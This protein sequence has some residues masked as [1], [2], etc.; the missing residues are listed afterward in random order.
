MKLRNPWLIRLA[1]FL[2]AGVVRLWMNTVRYRY[3]L[4]G[5]HVHPNDPELD[6]RYVYAFWHEAML[7]PGGQRWRGRVNVLISQHA[8]GELITQVVRHL[9]FRVV[10]GSTTRGGVK[11]IREMLRKSRASHLAVTPDGPRGPRRHVQPGVIYLAAKT[12]MPI[13][14]VGVGFQKA[15]RARSWDRFAV[16]YPWSTAVCVAGPV[17]FVPPEVEREEMDRYRQLLEERML[18]ATAQAEQAAGGEVELNGGRALAD[19]RK[20]AG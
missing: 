14:P 4:N 12:G 13:V 2:G 10:R 17:L 3:I 5:Q 7:I 18:Q 19:Q 9:G 16:P 15:W 6:R 1:G 8:D 20:A 11:A